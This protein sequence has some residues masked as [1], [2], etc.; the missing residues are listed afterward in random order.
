[1]TN[2]KEP[3][4]KIVAKSKALK[5]AGREPL[6]YMGRSEQ[7]DDIYCNLCYK[8]KNEKAPWN[9]EVNAL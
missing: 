9:K 3:M 8:G 4:A 5:A 6:G 7:C 2:Y 1:M